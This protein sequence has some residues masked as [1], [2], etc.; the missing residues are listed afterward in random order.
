M[1]RDRKARQLAAEDRE[2]Y[3][4]ILQNVKLAHSFKKYLIYHELYS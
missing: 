4:M 3:G 2:R 1:H